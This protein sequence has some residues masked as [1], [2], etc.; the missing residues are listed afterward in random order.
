MNA[1]RGTDAQN[2]KSYGPYSEESSRTH[3]LTSEHWA[4]VVL[5][6]TH[7]ENVLVEYCL[8]I[9]LIHKLNRT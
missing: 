5:K 9:L 6:E 1:H 8:G 3:T 2:F 4:W 7:D